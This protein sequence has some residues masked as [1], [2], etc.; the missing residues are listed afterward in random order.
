M[1]ELPMSG[2]FGSIP[3]SA[4]RG[5]A[6]WEPLDT[7]PD[8][9]NFKFPG[10]FSDPDRFRGAFRRFEPICGRGTTTIRRWPNETGTAPQ[11]PDLPTMRR[12]P[13][14]GPG[15]TRGCHPDRGMARSAVD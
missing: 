7:D 14:R 13:Q 8:P 11:W 9:A 12:P 6:P 10:G 5:A 15:D 3:P 4:N 1:N 2:S